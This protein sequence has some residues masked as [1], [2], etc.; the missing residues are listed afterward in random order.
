MGSRHAPFN[1]ALLTPV[2]GATSISYAR[3]SPSIPG[4]LESMPFWYSLP[5]L[6]LDRGYLQVLADLTSDS[7]RFVLFDDSGKI[8]RARDLVAPMGIFTRD[9]ERLLGMHVMN[10]PEIVEYGWRWR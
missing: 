1:W 7:R 3:Q 9:G 4:F 6:D 2:G 5:V 10:A 8:T